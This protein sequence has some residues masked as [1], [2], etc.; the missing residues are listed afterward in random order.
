MAGLKPVPALKPVAFVLA[1]DMAVAYCMSHAPRFF[2]SAP[3]G[4]DA[5]SSIGFVFPLFGCCS[6]PPAAAP[7]A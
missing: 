5:R 6:A 2:F 3:N 7:G 4:S 1:G